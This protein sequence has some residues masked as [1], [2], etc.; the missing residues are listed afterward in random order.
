[1]QHPSRIDY[2]N[3]AFIRQVSRRVL[4][5][6]WSAVTAAAVA[7]VIMAVPGPAGLAAA[8]QSALPP[9]NTQ[10]LAQA[11]AGLPS[12]QQA[13]AVVTVTGRSG[14]WSGTSGLADLATGNPA[15]AADEVRIGSISK[16]FIATVVLQLVAQHRISLDK[17]VQQ[18]LP[19]LL[20]R[21][22][23]PITIAELLD[24]T[25]GLGPADGTV[26]TG[27]P[28]WFLANRLGTYTTSQ[29]LG[30]VLQQ[31]LIFPPGTRQQ[32]NGVNYIVL[33]MLIQ[34][35]TGHGYA[36]EIERRIVG[37]LGMDRTYI[38]ATN[39]AMPSPY[40]H[41]YYQQGAAEP[42]TD[43]SG[44]SPTLF[45][46]QGAM[47]STT[48]DLNRFITALLRG[49]LLPPAEL[50]DMFAI[51]AAASGTIRYG[52]GLLAYTLPNGVT[53]WGHTGETPGYASGVFATRDLART[54]AYAITPVGP[55]SAS[56]VLTAELRIALAAYDPSPTG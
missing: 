28:Q 38:P 47:I 21:D 8:A 43:I 18:Y 45:G 30:P 5:A 11:I 17:P 15:T 6:R 36:Q 14:S 20:D 29:L 3:L 52:M 42:L 1:M 2:M 54:I 56:Q 44:Q 48:G 23:P 13:A 37:P 10:A 46:A 19:G 16:T 39:P 32:Y 49:R 33:A 55:A 34:K 53:V 25:S 22:D 26:N 50:N 40:L 9:L 35:V 12:S 31:P 7:F 24:H 41:G 4:I 27:D 51:P